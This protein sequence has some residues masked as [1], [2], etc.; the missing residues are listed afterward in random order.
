MSKKI[1]KASVLALALF[2]CTLSVFI[3]TCAQSTLVGIATQEQKFKVSV[4]G[5]ESNYKTKIFYQKAKTSNSIAVI[6]L[7]G[8]GAGLPEDYAQEYAKKGYVGVAVE[9]FGY[10]PFGETPF[11]ITNLPLEGFKDIIDSLRSNPSLQI[12]KIILRGRSR[13][14]ELALLIAEHFSPS[15]DGVIAEVPSAYVW[16]DR[17]NGIWSKL[18]PW[19]DQYPAS[20]T[21]ISSWTLAG[22]DIPFVP[23]A[24][25]LHDF[26]KETEKEN[27]PLFDIRLAYE[28]ASQNASTEALE[29]ARIKVEKISAPILVTGGLQDGLWPSAE[30][31]TIIKNTRKSAGFKKDIYLIEDAGH[32]WFDTEKFILFPSGVYDMYLTKESC[33]P[34]YIQS[35]LKYS[36]HKNEATKACTANPEKKYFMSPEYGINGYDTSKN[37]ESNIKFKNAE[38]KFLSQF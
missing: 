13:G 10:D 18:I 27:L 14:G 35:N 16:G 5:A 15:V 8:S 21:E 28:H 4:L 17:A 20:Q 24:G 7:P 1:I 12:K 29:N 3:E 34:N 31:A 38:D 33:Q 6:V 25:L 2:L 36:E 32:I 30:Y 19:E 9:Y 23:M 26:S 37:L 22:K 11:S